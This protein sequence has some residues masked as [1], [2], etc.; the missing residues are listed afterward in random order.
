M[1]E[2]DKCSARG[3]AHEPTE[4]LEAFRNEMTQKYFH[5]NVHPKSKECMNYY[6]IKSEYIQCIKCIN[7][8]RRINARIYT[9][10]PNGRIR[11]PVCHILCNLCNTQYY[12]NIYVQAAA[13]H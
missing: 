8:P 2:M 11:L 12:Y 4:L 10:Y 9:H 13:P 7:D 6:I 5:A 3:F 1:E